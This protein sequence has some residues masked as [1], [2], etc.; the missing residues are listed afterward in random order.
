MKEKRQVTI[1]THDIKLIKINSRRDL[2][3]HE[4][5]KLGTEEDED[6]V[7]HSESDERELSLI[8]DRILNMDMNGGNK[9]PCITKR[10]KQGKECESTGG[11][12]PV[13][14]LGDTSDEGNEAREE[15]KDN[16][17][18]MHIHSPQ[19]PSLFERASK[20]LSHNS[21]KQI[22]IMQMNIT[23]TEQTENK[24][25]SAKNHL[26]SGEIKVGVSTDI[27]NIEERVY[28]ILEGTLQSPTGV[29]LERKVGSHNVSTDMFEE[30]LGED[31]MAGVFEDTMTEDTL[32]KVFEDTMS[33]GSLPK[34]FEGSVSE[35]TLAL[36][37]S[38]PN[39]KIVQ[40]L[41]SNIVTRHNSDLAPKFMSHDCGLHPPSMQ[42]ES[43]SYLTSSVN[44]SPELK[45][46][47]HYLETEDLRGWSLEEHT[48]VKL[49]N[50]VYNGDIHK[51]KQSNMPSPPIKSVYHEESVETEKQD[52]AP[53]SSSVSSPVCKVF[54]ETK[55][56]YTH[57]KL[58]YGSVGTDNICTLKQTTLSS[59]SVFKASKGKELEDTSIELSSRFVNLEES[60]KENQG[61]GSL[62]A[63]ACEG[64]GVTQKNLNFLG[65]TTS[66]KHTAESWC[67][68]N[69][70]FI[71]VKKEETRQF[72][73][74]DVFFDGAHHE[75]WKEGSI[76][77]PLTGGPQ[78][79]TDAINESI[80]EVDNKVSQQQTGEIN[81]CQSYHTC[82]ITQLSSNEGKVNNGDEME[83][84]S[85]TPSSTSPSGPGGRGQSLDPFSPEEVTLT[86]AQR[87]RQK[88]SDKQFRKLLDDLG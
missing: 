37:S 77:K 80:D 10:Y 52:G 82:G 75:S 15:T 61:N 56:S 26:S 40:S 11:F 12:I 79:N 39:L 38:L 3:H 44:Y 45:P 47:I 27:G 31:T 21:K 4:I 73:D 55:V 49:D 57:V 19:T 22:E 7:V 14:A 50:S 30:S 42:P 18:L 46:N 28:G 6:E 24:F 23:T 69:K 16:E 71:H 87:L 32:T 36:N 34:M 81:S 17:N 29:D 74:L 86:L 70:Y 78:Y 64:V 63:S 5:V 8:I 59:P 68:T 84:L 72:R 85:V 65:N 54:L 58:S 25:V 9:Q 43:H 60:H 33:E 67:P 53:F 35:G 83:T 13:Q 88:C 1:N 76:Y 41:K 20:R 51:K 2:Q 48:G 62:L 66:P